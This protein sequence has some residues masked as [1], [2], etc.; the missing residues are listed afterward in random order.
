[1]AKKEVYQ[2]GQCGRSRYGKVVTT[3]KNPN[4]WIYRSWRCCNTV[5]RP[6]GQIEKVESFL[7]TERR[8]AREMGD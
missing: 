6:T 3:A 5:M 4:P 2:C 8:L 1:M 7:A